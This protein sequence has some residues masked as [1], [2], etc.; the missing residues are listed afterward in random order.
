MTLEL[1]ENL[2]NSITSSVSGGFQSLLPI[3]AI[4]IGVNLA[5]FALRKIIFIVTL[6]KR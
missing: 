2:V 3:F 6:T 1:S 5:F 4:I